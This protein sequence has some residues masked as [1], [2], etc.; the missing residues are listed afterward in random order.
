MKNNNELFLEHPHILDVQIKRNS[1][2]PR[3]QNLQN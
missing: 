1:M 2:S 3:Y